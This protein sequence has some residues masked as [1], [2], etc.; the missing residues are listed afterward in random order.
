MAIDPAG[1]VW[2]SGRGSSGEFLSE[3]NSSGAGLAFSESRPAN[4]VAAGLALDSNGVLHLAG[5]TGLIS[6]F[7]PSQSQAPRIF[8]VANAAGGAL[9]GRI[10][11]GEILSIYG[12]H[13]GPAANSK[14]IAS[15]FSGFNAGLYVMF[16][17]DTQINAIVP[18]LSD[19]VSTMLQ[20]TVNGVSLGPMRLAID[21]V[22]PEIFQTS[23]GSAAVNQDGT[24]NSSTNPA[25]TGSFV[26]IYAS[27]AGGSGP[28][29]A[30]GAY[31]Y[32]HTQCA[33]IIPAGASPVL[34]GSLYVPYCGAAPGLIA[35]V[36]QI[37]FQIPPA[38][39]PH[40]SVELNVDGIYSDPITLWVAP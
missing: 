33:I 25:K 21:P 22:D 17:S 39:P 24:L 29:I 40:I 8:G 36:T 10:A 20:L 7:T 19:A 28:E 27:G 15:S 13:F 23:S 11:N 34:N 9:S 35:S 16:V 6:T 14:D 26:S 2:L 1:N 18:N 38:F 37:D 31:Q 12:E 32:T 30:S 3:M 5:S 4:T